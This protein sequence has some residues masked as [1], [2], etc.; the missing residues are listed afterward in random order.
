MQF[1]FSTF[2]FL[3][4]HLKTQGLQLVFK[5]VMTKM[6]LLLYN[7]FS[8]CLRS[9]WPVAF[10]FLCKGGFKFDYSSMVAES[11]T[12]FVV[13]DCFEC[14][15]LLGQPQSPETTKVQSVACHSC[16]S[17]HQ[18]VSS[19]TDHVM[20]NGISSP[21]GTRRK[22][23][24]KKKKGQRYSTLNFHKRGT[25]NSGR[26]AASGSS[27]WAKESCSNRKYCYC[28][29]KSCGKPLQ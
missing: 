17:V 24:L 8:E 5:C 9:V 15:A 18:N 12:K 4:S 1:L 23:N 28:M 14:S 10:T 13:C 26:M 20:I 27:Q 25:A 3:Y 2:F 6:K 22:W 29:S 16:Q 21:L 11:P 19:T 7:T